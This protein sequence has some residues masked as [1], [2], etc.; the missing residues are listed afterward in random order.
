[1]TAFGLR[2]SGCRALHTFSGRSA[3]FNVDGYRPNPD[4]Q[5]RSLHPVNR[6][7]YS[8]WFASRRCLRDYLHRRQLEQSDGQETPAARVVPRYFNL[9]L[10]RLFCHFAEHPGAIR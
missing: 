10:F 9:G 2:F 1:M 4:L 3:P 8:A 6:P 5:E 7:H